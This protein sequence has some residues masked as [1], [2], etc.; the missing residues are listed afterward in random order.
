MAIIS[1]DRRFVTYKSM[2]AFPNVTCFT[3]TRYGGVSEGNYGSLNCGIYT[4]DDPE[5]IKQNLEIV[6]NALPKKPTVLAI[7]HLAHGT[8]YEHL[9]RSFLKGTE[10]ERKARLEQKDILM[11]RE[12][13]LCV[14]VTSADCLPIAI[15]DDR[16]EA[17]CIVH[18]GWRGTV[19][20]VTLT[21]LQKMQQ[22]FE[23]QPEDVHV[24]IGPGISL[25]GFE[26]G[27]EVYEQFKASSYPIEHVAEW[28]PRSHK[29]HINLWVA[30]RLDLQEFGVPSSQIEMSGIC[31]YLRYQEFFSVRRLSRDSGRQL[32][33]IMLNK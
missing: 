16:H 18:A 12:K 2:L 27:D 21:A 7:P 29:Y 31:T 24:V 1:E 5:K 13:G 8:D 19:N 15:Y 3:T 32:T 20:H 26:V 9:G 23:T 17:V 28:V 22:K 33:G 10:E 25:A 14:C 11:T 4:D 30:N 6:R